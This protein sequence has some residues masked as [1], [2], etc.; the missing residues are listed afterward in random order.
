MYLREVSRHD[1]SHLDP[2]SFDIAGCSDLQT[3]NRSLH[4]NLGKCD[5]RRYHCQQIPI[6]YLSS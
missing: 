6:S 1:S 4:H 2:G 5:C 3:A